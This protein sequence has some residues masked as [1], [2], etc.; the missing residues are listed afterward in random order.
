MPTTDKDSRD[1]IF[2]VIRSRHTQ[3]KDLI[4]CQKDAPQSLFAEFE[5]MFWPANPPQS[6]NSGF[7]KDFIKQYLEPML[8][9]SNANE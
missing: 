8:L 3:L 7:G 5:Q 6:W 1:D 9:E 4:V 2:Q